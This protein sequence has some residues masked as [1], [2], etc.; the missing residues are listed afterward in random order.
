MFS[1]SIAW[2]MVKLGR[3]NVFFAAFLRHPRDKIDDRRF[4]R[5]FVP[6]GKHAQLEPPVASCIFLRAS[7]MVKVFGFCTGGNSLNV[8]ANFEA[9]IWAA[10]TR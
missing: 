9:A 6:G 7:S 4:R 1:F 8:S 3:R 10:K 2:S 5:A